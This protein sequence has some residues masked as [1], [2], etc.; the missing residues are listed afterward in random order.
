MQGLCEAEAVGGWEYEDK[1]VA[2]SLGRGRTRSDETSG[3]T[4]LIVKVYEP[5]KVG[6]KRK[7]KQAENWKNW[8]RGE[9]VTVT[10]YFTVER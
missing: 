8:S 7:A 3:L 5:C 9:V 10:H 6:Q 4:E 1:R 2:A